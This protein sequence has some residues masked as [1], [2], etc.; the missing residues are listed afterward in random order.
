MN[1][2]ITG[3]SG[4]LGRHVADKFHGEGNKVY[5]ISRSMVG[6]CLFDQYQIDLVK[7]DYKILPLLREKSIDI[8]VHLA[9]KPIVSDCNDSPYEAI[10][11]NGMTTAA[12][13]EAAR[14]A[15]VERTLVVETDK[16]YGVQSVL[17]TEESCFLNPGSPYEYSKVVAA[18][19]CD[20]YRNHYKQDI[21]SIRPANL[22][23]PGDRSFSRI[24]PACMKNIREGKNLP[25]YTHAKDMKRDFIYVSD[26]AS[27]I[28]I[29]ATEKVNHPVYNLSMG[30]PT[31]IWDL[32]TR[33]TEILRCES[34]PELITANFDAPEIPEQWIS[35]ERFLHE[36][37][38]V[39]TPFDDAIRETYKYY[40]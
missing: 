19:V 8:V 7:E 38:F 40:V 35:G 23:G 33:I 14:L 28:Y 25:V 15:Q 21:I 39:F 5:G 22:F 36:F 16:V 9:G 2:L 17:P 4:F 1:V 3:H 27:M 18:N 11:A 10:K 29:L 13:I 32:A 24:I 37:N 6:N 20:F 12:V 26:V 30:K 31:S 34:K